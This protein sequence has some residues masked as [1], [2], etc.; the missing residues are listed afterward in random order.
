MLYLSSES[1]PAIIM[2]TV[3]T[4]FRTVRRGFEPYAEAS[5]VALSRAI[6]G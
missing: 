6:I 5:P 3:A 1:L 2:G 4:V